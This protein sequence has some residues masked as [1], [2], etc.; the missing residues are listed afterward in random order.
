MDDNP[1]SNSLFVMD[2]SSSL[3]TANQ[4]LAHARLASFGTAWW[5]RKRMAQERNPLTL[6]IRSKISPS[7]YFKMIE[8]LLRAMRREDASSVRNPEDECALLEG[9][10]AVKVK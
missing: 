5:P 2:A 7:S 9:I 1:F 8:G 3:H 10:K 6:H 4:T